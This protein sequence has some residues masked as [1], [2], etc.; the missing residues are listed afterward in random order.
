MTT[1]S[2]S[3]IAISFFVSFFLCTN[4]TFAFFDGDGGED[5]EDAFPFWPP[6][7]SQP[8]IK[9][10][11]GFNS[12]GKSF[13]DEVDKRGLVTLTEMAS[14]E[15]YE[16]ITEERRLFYEAAKMGNHKGL[17][18]VTD[19]YIHR[20]G[21]IPKPYPQIVVFAEI[22]LQHA[23]A[24]N[25]LARHCI[26]KFYDKGIIGASWTKE[27]RQKEAYNWYVKAAEA[28]SVVSMPALLN[29]LLGEKE[30]VAFV[31]SDSQRRGQ[32]VD[33]FVKFGPQLDQP[34]LIVTVLRDMGLEKEV[35][36]FCD[37]LAMSALTNHRDLKWW[38][39]FF[40]SVCRDQQDRKK[41]TDKLI[42]SLEG[43]KKSEAEDIAD[44]VLGNNRPVNDSEKIYAATMRRVIE[45]NWSPPLLELGSQ[46]KYTEIRFEIDQFGA[47]KNLQIRYSSGIAVY[48]E[49]AMQAIRSS[50][51]PKPA[52][53]PLAVSFI[54]QGDGQDRARIRQEVHHKVQSAWFSF[55]KQLPLIEQS[56]G[57]IFLPEGLV[58]D[59]TLLINSE[60]R[61]ENVN[62]VRF[63]TNPDINKYARMAIEKSAP[64]RILV[65]TQKNIFPMKV[66]LDFQS[67]MFGK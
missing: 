25:P 28:G 3:R 43:N 42:A 23:Q 33:L 54:F 46:K 57:E 64:V 36:L 58:P 41:W 18:Y 10:S 44:E 19:D 65:S 52:K 8:T 22:L 35:H 12:E 11:N 29:Q 30:L 5:P 37:E 26:A 16:K 45:S 9:S 50:K 51:F 63:S 61:F 32:L 47:P 53:P 14:H 66:R 1:S 67:I 56:K 59:I 49:Q 38:R 6:P 24:R 40:F 60:G 31:K 48:D 2:K 34:G 17:L 13:I 15:G 62:F 4:L 20:S 21:R 39:M 55:Q 27:R 7:M